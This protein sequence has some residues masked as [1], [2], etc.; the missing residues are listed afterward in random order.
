MAQIVYTE[1]LEL[2]GNGRSYWLVRDDA[3]PLLIYGHPQPFEEV[4]VVEKA[5]SRKSGRAHVGHSADGQ[6]AVRID[7]KSRLAGELL[8]E[9]K[10]GSWSELDHI[11]M[12]QYFRGGGSYDSTGEVLSLRALDQVFFDM[13]DIWATVGQLKFWIT[14]GGNELVF[15][16]DEWMTDNLRCENQVRALFTPELLKGYMANHP[17][18]LE[19]RCDRFNL[20]M[21]RTL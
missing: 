17:A 21:G 11:F 12:L 10:L 7:P 20:R 3:P 19:V 2:S 5:L 9:L 16:A 8:D 15:E 18:G 14:V 4:A 1:P 13:I 6:K